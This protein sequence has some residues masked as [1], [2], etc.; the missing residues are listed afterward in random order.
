VYLPAAPPEPAR[1]LSCILT[2]GQREGPVELLEVDELGGR[3]TVRNSGTEMLLTL[4]NEKSAPQ[5]PPLPPAPP[6]P[7]MRSA[8]R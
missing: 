4:E 8:S 2:V 6:P 5:K 3:A 7:P 1:E